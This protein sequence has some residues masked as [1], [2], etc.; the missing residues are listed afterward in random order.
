LE[1][2]RIENM[3]NA[4]IA[5]AIIAM[6]DQQAHATTL[7]TNVNN[8]TNAQNQGQAQGQLQGQTQAAIGVGIA[9]VKSNISN[10]VR[11]R[12]ISS[13]NNLGNSLTVNEAPIPANTSERLHIDDYSVKNVPSV[14]TGSVYPTAPC[15]G[16]SQA[17]VGWVGAGVSFGTSWTD[18][19]CGIRETS[20]SFAGMDLKEDALAVLC[21]SKYAA[22]APS[23]K[24]LLNK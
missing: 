2:W 3:K 10:D 20:R 13:A 17:G 22:A 6:F 8:N 12:A 11:N 9:V 14:L 5:L 19:E 15:M 23:C 1:L 24:A 18:D 16:S 21:T 4:I 7:P